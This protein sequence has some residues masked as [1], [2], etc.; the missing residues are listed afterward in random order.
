MVEKKLKLMY[1]LLVYSECSSVAGCGGEWHMPVDCDSADL[2]ITFF[3][4][5]LIIVKV[6]I[7]ILMI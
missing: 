6:I 1:S 7:V 3:V 4:H 2:L 5:L